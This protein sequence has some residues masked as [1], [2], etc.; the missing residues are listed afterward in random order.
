M[1]A[2]T[3]AEAPAVDIDQIPSCIR[4]NSPTCDSP[5]STCYED[6]DRFAIEHLYA[7]ADVDESEGK[8]ERADQ[9]RALAREIRTAAQSQTAEISTAT[10][11]SLPSADEI[12]DSAA[13]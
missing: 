6:A 9:W 12:A 7:M 8:Y 5:T 10:A 1:V 11:E 4:A 3:V 13:K 2:E